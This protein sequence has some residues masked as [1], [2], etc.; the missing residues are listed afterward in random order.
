M[1]SRQHQYIFEPVCASVLL[2][3]N[4]SKEPL[5]SRHTP[6]IEG[7]V[8]LQP[9]CLRMSQVCV[10]HLHVTHHFSWVVRE[11]AE[12]SKDR[13]TFSDFILQTSVGKT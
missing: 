5:R 2:R 4:T 6:R 13:L 8:Q 10:N 9:M 11:E 7:Q 1:Q 3:R 12:I